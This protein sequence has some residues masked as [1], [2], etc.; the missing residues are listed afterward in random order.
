MMTKIIVIRHG[1]TEW[2]IGQV[3]RGRA[4]IP[5]NETGKK[6]AE[7]LA[8]ALGFYKMAAIYSSPL[9]RAK[10][11]AEAVAKKQGLEVKISKLLLDINYGEW[12]GLTH[13]EVRK[14]WPKIYR[15]WH[16]A[17]EKVKFPEGES[18]SEVKKR[19]V[20]FL[21]KVVLKHQNETIAAVSHRVAIKVLLRA[22]LGIDNS[23]F[24]QLRQNTASFSVLEYENKVF[25]LTCL[26]E[27]C[28]LKGIAG[29][30]DKV[31]F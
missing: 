1:Q 28:Y 2:N 3:F 18:L 12:Q 19:V 22:A 5:L 13:E 23:H 7:S 8:R 11:T 14:K 30:M 31:D 20:Q 27:T 25:S 24:W 16:E 6:Q 15:A 21:K 29:G 26:N 4:D 10:E 9:S 17:P